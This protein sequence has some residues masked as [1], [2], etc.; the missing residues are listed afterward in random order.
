MRDSYR[1]MSISC[2]A[3]ALG[4]SSVLSFSSPAAAALGDCAQPSSSGATP[5]AT[6]ALF[7]LN[8]AVGLAMCEACVCDVDGSRSI[9]APDALR[10]LQI[11]V[12]TELSL[13]CPP[14]GGGPTSTVST[15]TSSTTSTTSTSTTLPLA[16]VD[17]EADDDRALAAADATCELDVADAG[18]EEAPACSIDEPVGAADDRLCSS[19]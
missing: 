11:A 17:V 5:T 15:S 3:L 10:A 2:A 16:A 7:I 4:L 8:A 13:D 18:V 12:G 19:D 14:C 9:T 1:S 6:D